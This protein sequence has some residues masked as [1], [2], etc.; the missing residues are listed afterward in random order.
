MARRFTV[1]WTAVG[2]L[3][4]RWKNAKASPRLGRWMGESRSLPGWG[5]MKPTAN[6]RVDV[7]RGRNRTTGRFVCPTPRT[8]LVSLAYDAA[9]W[10]NDLALARAPQPLTP[11]AVG[12]KKA[13]ACKLGN[14][15]QADRHE[16]SDMEDQYPTGKPTWFGPRGEGI[17]ATGLTSGFWAAAIATGLGFKSPILRRNSNGRIGQVC[18]PAFNRPTASTGGPPNGCPTLPAPSAGPADM[19]HGV[20]RSTWRGSRHKTQKTSFHVTQA[21]RSAPPCCPCGAM[22]LRGNLWPLAARP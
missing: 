10:G 3:R 5:R 6:G 12:M 13:T 22:K 9:R 2:R 14:R 11:T 8:P 7:A 17:L 1:N 20:G 18:W 21:P 15:S 4:V 19:G 16:R